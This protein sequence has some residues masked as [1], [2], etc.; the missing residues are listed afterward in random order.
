MNLHAGRSDE[1]LADKL[2][3]VSPGHAAMPVCIPWERASRQMEFGI[4]EIS[5]P[6]QRLY[7]RTGFF[8]WDSAILSLAFSE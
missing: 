5:I 1:D 8:E 4:L 3:S 7:E 6:I 2:S